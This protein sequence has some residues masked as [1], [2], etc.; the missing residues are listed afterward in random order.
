MTQADEVG[1]GVAC[2]AQSEKLL[3]V[4]NV[5]QT[6]CQRRHRGTDTVSSAPLFLVGCEAVPFRGKGKMIK[7]VESIIVERFI[8]ETCRNHF[9]WMLLPPP[10]PAQMQ[11]AAEQCPHVTRL[12]SVLDMG[13]FLFISLIS[14]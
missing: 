12:P 11:F 3:P 13:K 1:E 10:H 9:V 2:A 14:I 6:R 8:G 4:C 5:G 7:M